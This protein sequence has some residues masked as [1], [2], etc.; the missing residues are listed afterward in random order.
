VPIFYVLIW[1]NLLTY[2]TDAAKL[3]FDRQIFVWYLH[4]KSHPTSVRS[5]VRE[6]HGQT[7]CVSRSLYNFFL[8]R[9]TKQ[10]IR[11]V[12]CNIKQDNIRCRK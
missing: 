7:L 3:K 1:G 2:L 5:L 8:F 11:R 6:T 12:L 4:A 10:I 9:K